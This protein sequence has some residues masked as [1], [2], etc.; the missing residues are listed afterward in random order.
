[1]ADWIQIDP[2][3]TSG[4]A[5]AALSGLPRGVEMKPVPVDPTATQFGT[6]HSDGSYY[7]F[8]AATQLGFASIADASASFQTKTY[9]FDLMYYA[10]STLISSPNG[11]LIYG[12]WWGAG[13]RI[14]IEAVNFTAKVDFNLATIAAAA[15]I[16]QTDASFSIE[17]LGIADISIFN[18]LPGPG[19]YD[20]NS[21]KQI[22]QAMADVENNILIPQKNLVAVPFMIWVANAGLSFG[23]PID[24][25]HAQLFAV[26]RIKD[27]V[28]QDQAIAAAS[29][30]GVDPATV[31]IV[32]TKWAG[33][34]STNLTPNATAVGRA[35]DWLS[36]SNL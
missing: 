19:R 35:K 4:G 33:T 16:G 15:S 13:L 29:L 22:L 24:R 26:R 30:A 36:R 9:A 2:T 18:L 10:S 25:A 34:S 31:E 5:F 3:L 1:M 28:P 17:G 32:Y 11:G 6:R 7:N 23:T 20:D 14:R 12:T 27:A 8:S 21:Y